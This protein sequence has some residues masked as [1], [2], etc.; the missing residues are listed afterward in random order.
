MNSSSR[1][2]PVSGAVVKLIAI[3]G[4]LALGGCEQLHKREQVITIDSKERL[5]NGSG[6][7]ES[8][9]VRC[10]YVVYGTKGEVLRN[11]DALV[12]GDRWKMDSATMQAGLRAG[13]TYHVNTIG[14]RI[15]FLSMMPN[16]IHA[17]EV[18]P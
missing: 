5:C 9:T 1:S 4:V 3:C 15:P 10:H 13:H 14:W 8:A 17:R 2:Q 18:K 6:T 11:E 12:F 7:G 16:I